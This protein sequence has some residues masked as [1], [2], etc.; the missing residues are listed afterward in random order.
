[1]SRPAK[2]AP[3]ARPA[4]A[5]PVRVGLLGFGTIGA[6]VV[7]VLRA[8]RADIARRVGR[9]ID[10]VAIADLDLKTDRGVAPEP[11]RFTNDARSVI[12]DPSIPI[13][14]ELIGGYEPARRF[15]LS[16]I[17]AGKDV[18]TANKALLAV[19]GEEIVAAAE[20]RGVRVGFEASVG[21]GIP[22]LRTLKEGLAGDRTTAVH[23]IVNG[24][25]NHILTTMTREGRSFDDVLIEA[26]RLGLAEADPS[27]D[28]DGIDS[29]HK[30][31]LLTTLAFGVA[32]RFA[33]IPTEGIRRIDALDI[34]F[35]RELGYTIK[36]LAVARDGKEAVE[37]HVQPTM[38]PNGHLLAD[39]AGNFNAIFVRGAALGPTMYYG[40]GAGAMPTATAVIA[41]LIA[42]A[43]DRS[44]G[45]AV[46]VPPWGVSQRA[47]RRLPVRPLAALEGE[48]YLRFMAL[49]R[50]GV[51]ARIAGV[52]GRNDISIASVIQK[53]RRAET[54]VPI[55]IRTH[56]ARQR[57]LA[58]ALAAIGRL[59]VV[60]G[61]PVEIRIE[62]QLG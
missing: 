32:P 56:H 10:I 31:A 3:R 33:D 11:A 54:T 24:T 41:D 36:L 16:A 58:R 9:P 59:D 26:Q 45:G 48:Y 29:A 47:L 2:S 44:V 22:I 1:M 43:R 23:G 13:I 6:G 50:P 40:Q 14:I 49:D 27:T 53:E 38:I 61:R 28:V 35:A 4:P 42:A 7:K 5:E 12:E 46:R 19:H 52:L 51:L 15:V 20:E 34:A 17:A 62:E 25:C 21:G 37:A 8:H 30:L 60:R 55:V 18:V 39:V 57:N